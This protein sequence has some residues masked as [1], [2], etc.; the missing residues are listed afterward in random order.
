[1]KK[2]KQI[3]LCGLMSALSIALLY[4][5]SVIWIF[6]YLM[7]IIASLIMII[8]INNL[9]NKYAWLVFGV[10]SVISILFSPDKECALTYTLF[11][12]YYPIIFENINKIKN[13]IVKL[14]VEFITFNISMVV[15]QLTCIYV[16]GIPFDNIFGKWG[17]IILLVFA[18]LLFVVYKKL[19]VVIQLLYLIKLHSKIKNLLN[20]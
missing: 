1:M 18:N 12:G 11:F 15:S 2:S 6:S 5:G 8:I 16:F 3:S 4:F 9:S 14:A 17:V 19:F 20:R 13:K 7:P 10:V